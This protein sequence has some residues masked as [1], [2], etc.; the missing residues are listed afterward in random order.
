MIRST[1]NGFAFVPL[2][3]RCRPGCCENHVHVA[4]L[5]RF[6]RKR[7]TEGAAGLESLANLMVAGGFMAA[8]GVLLALLPP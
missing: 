5:F 7:E 8:L 3:I 4:V 2:R 6:K 1:T